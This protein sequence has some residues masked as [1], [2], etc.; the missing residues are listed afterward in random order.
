MNPLEQLA[1]AIRRATPL[2]A[3]HPVWRVVR[4]AY[5]RLLESIGRKG[6]VRRINGTDSIRLVPELY[7][8][9]ETYEPDVWRTLMA[10]VRRDDTV[11]DVGAAIGLYTLALAAR[12]GPHG[13]VFAF[14]PDPSSADLLAKNVELSPVRERIVV[15]RVALGDRRGTA[16]FA[17]GAGLESHIATQSNVNGTTLV[18]VELTTLD[19]AFGASHIDI[20][21]VDVEG[22]EERVLRGGVRMLSDSKRA[23]RVLFLEVHPYAW[24]ALGASSASLLDLLASCDY[25]VSDLSGEPVGEIQHYG[26]VLA[27]RRA[28]VP[29]SVR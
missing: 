19:E 6:L 18:E 25:D 17:A 2:S 24:P 16:S 5:T 1:V 23:P 28:R 3:E 4:P 12:V 11:V 29:Q 8:V 20:L 7:T 14:E 10:E 15:R 9:G 26:E 27:W 13:R 22:F 21:K